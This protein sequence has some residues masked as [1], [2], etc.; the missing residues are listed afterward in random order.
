MTNED[1]LAALQ[2]E[3]DGFAKAVATDEG[4][5]IIKGFI[6]VHKRIY[7]ISVD[8]KIVSKVLELLLFPLFVEFGKKHGLRLDL[9]QQQ[10]FYPDVSFVEEST[11]KK[12]A[13]DI[14][15]TY[16]T[17]DDAVNGMT[18]GAFTGY[19]RNRKST[20][21]IRYPYE[22]YEGHFVLGV[23]YTQ[24]LEAIDERAVFEIDDLDKIPSVIHSFQFFAQPK[25]KI[26]VGRPGSGNTK[27]IGSCQ[28]ISDLVNGT[29]PFSTLGEDVYDDYWMF[30][31]TKDMAKALEIERPY[32]SIKTFL[33]YKKKGI[34]TLTEHEEEI[35]Q[36]GDDESGEEEES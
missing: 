36:L 12:Y 10:N 26:A 32:I 31:L 34:A 28:K 2:A 5:W 14:K 27:N 4:Q 18:L 6:D 22:E 3:T 30:Y 7:T 13:V 9:S 20:K 21:N 8:T 25:Y 24:C 35:K 11:G 33:E 29:G 17:S 23:I 15:S 1:F 19:F 16:R